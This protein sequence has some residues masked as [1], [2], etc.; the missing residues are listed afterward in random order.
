MDGFRV[1]INAI[2]H[3]QAPPSPYTP[4]LRND[5]SASQAYQLP[6]VPVIRIF[7]ATTAG[8]KVC[9]HVHGFFPY[10]YVPYEGSLE[11]KK[12]GA[13]IYRL[14]VSID[15]ALSLIVRRPTSR[16]SR[17]PKFVARITLV[18]GV[19]FYGFHVGYS[20]FLKIYMF[21]PNIMNRLVDVLQ[22]GAIM[23]TRFQPYEAHIQ[24]LSQFMIDYNLFGCDWLDADKTHFRAPLPEACEGDARQLPDDGNKNRLRGSESSLSLLYNDS[25]VPAC[26]VT[27]DSTLPRSSYCTLEVDIT[28]CDITN[29]R[30][31]TERCLHHDFIE[32]LYPVPESVKLVPSMAGLW[33]SEEQ[34]RRALGLL[35]SNSSPF[36]PDVL[37]SMSPDK[38]G[39]IE[40]GFMGEEEQRKQVA[41]LIKAEYDPNITPSFETFVKHHP[42]AD[43]VRTVMESVEDLYPDNLQAVLGL[44][45]QGVDDASVE[46]PSLED[47][48]VDEVQIS[49]SQ[50]PINDD[51]ANEIQDA[52][53]IDHMNGQA[54]RDFGAQSP[55]A[56][57]NE[58]ANIEG[59]LAS[60]VGLSRSGLYSGT[61]P[62]ISV[63]TNLIEA[64]CSDRF[65]P[66]LRRVP[67][68][69]K[70]RGKRFFTS[71]PAVTPDFNRKKM[72]IG[73]DPSFVPAA[74]KESGP[75]DVEETLAKGKANYDKK[76]VSFKPLMDANQALSVQRDSQPAMTED[77]HNIEGWLQRN[78]DL[79]SSSPESPSTPA[80]SRHNRAGF[81]HH[82]PL[83]VRSSQDA[84][85]PAGSQLF[86]ASSRAPPVSPFL[87]R[88]PRNAQ[89]SLI[90]TTPFK[91]PL[92]K[93]SWAV[94][95]SPFSIRKVGCSSSPFPACKQTPGSTTRS[96]LLQRTA[97]THTFVFS[98]PPPQ[99]AEVCSSFEQYDLPEVINEEVTY[100]VEADVPAR[101]HEY[102]GKTFRLRSNTLPFLPEFEIDA[103]HA[104][105]NS[106]LLDEPG[107]KI[108]KAR[109]IASQSRSLPQDV[110]CQMCSI[111]SWDFFPP[112]PSFQEVKA[113]DMARHVASM[114]SSRPNQ[115]LSSQSI[116]RSQRFAS[117]IDGPT[118]A[119]RGS[120]AITASQRQRSTGLKPETRSMS[121]LAIEVH[122]NT[123]GKLMPNPEH[124]SV[125]FV[126]WSLQTD[127]SYDDVV[128]L[129]DPTPDQ[130]GI[131]SGVI[132]LSE[133]S[134]E[135]AQ[136]IKKQT[137]WVVQAED[138][139]LE[140]LTAVA[141]MVRR[142]DP[143][144]LT[145][146]EVHS[147]SWGFLLER[148]ATKYEYDLG[149]DLSRMRGD[150]AS[151]L[152]KDGNGARWAFTK[153]STVKVTGRHTINIWRAMRGEMSLSQYTME[154]VAWHLLGRRIP[155]YSHAVLTAW[156]KAS[157]SADACAG[158]GHRA[159]ARLL[160]YYQLRTR[161]DLEIL[162]ANELVARTREQAR[163]LGVDFFSVIS[164]G[165]Q[166]K[167]ESMMGRIA[168]PENY[169]FVSPSRK[170]VGGQNA[171]ECLPLV[172]EP[173][174]ALYT[175]P[176]VVLD[177]QSL[178]PS[179]MIAYN[180]CYSTF[181][182]RIV[183]WGS[184]ATN[185]MGFTQYTRAKHLLTL[186][187]NSVTIAPNGMM[188]VT[189]AVRTSLLAKMLREIL[190]TRVMVK[191]GMKNAKKSVHQLLNNRQL[192]LKLLAN[193]TYG[194]TSASY[195]GR[196]PCAEIADSIVQT[197]R[198]TL[199][200]AIAL[201]H[202]HPSW[203]AEVVYGDTDSLFIRLPGRTK[204][205]AFSI[206]NEMA[207]AI[208]AAN[209]RP[210]KIK[211]EKIYQPCV[212]LAKKR[213]VG[214][215]WEHPSQDI[216]VFEAK[217]I[218]TVRRD[219]TPGEQK[220]QE[221]VLRTL[222]DTADLSRV[223]AYFQRQCDKILRGHV[224]LQ[225]FCF[226]K[227]VKLGTYADSSGGVHNYRRPNQP[228]PPALPPGALLAA[229][230]MLVDGRA[231]P[232]YGERVPYLV[233]AGAPGSRL[234]DRCVAPSEVLDSPDA[235]L[236]ADYYI[237]K[238]I[239]PAIDR[240][241]QLV[242]ASAKR[243]Y[244]E[245]PKVKRVRRIDPKRRSAILE[246]YLSVAACIA[247]K[248]HLP[249]R[250]AGTA[251][252]AKATPG[253]GAGDALI[254]MRCLAQRPQTLTTIQRRMS[255]LSTSLGN[256]RAVC[257][258]CAATA[259]GDDIDCDSLDCS[260]F[261]T[262][263]KM[264][265]RTR[266]EGEMLREAERKLLE[267]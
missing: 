223:K 68:T 56:A 192:A 263:S 253:G 153:T 197:S 266:S 109:A 18:K 97:R 171:L 204:A 159:M 29:R 260:V 216:P 21:N 22:N 19:P 176:V 256:I 36:P 43:T 115:C 151:R 15:H 198:E 265:A 220:I 154:N 183:G 104:S 47:I 131:V 246:A 262:R 167:V 12:V 66:G 239:I 33:R 125:Q 35:A 89:R 201:I 236:D 27:D 141:A 44:A 71:S 258:S 231:E 249:P 79:I 2:D 188:Y 61:P 241:L 240:I 180:Y 108:N 45:P 134:T 74:I 48:E 90:F 221:K 101:P 106:N 119:K 203:K 28:V 67:G 13:Y 3:Y 14:H 64:A 177:F 8:Q 233:I 46:N 149:E 135:L 226:A 132:V 215:K 161:L 172:M 120:V 157:S 72:K 191:S 210:V 117:Q 264:E 100:S 83:P 139:E 39:T 53:D 200:R 205:S 140:V 218:E 118:P 63:D 225:D 228:Q 142:F 25:T 227:E 82:S 160:R 237:N 124:D 152:H 23:Q 76:R 42:R 116:L 7:G 261:W 185:K 219:G 248:S 128:D 85:S 254:C 250:T 147:G 11:P 103:G 73:P 165:S 252:T 91:T 235:E 58:E 107:S 81:M 69:T 207:V 166:F 190:E 163:L 162:E 242:G 60:F 93:L 243:W 178:Y 70:A 9:A 187:Q 230:K 195:S 105:S 51:V 212:L 224:S 251:I 133:E 55:E 123:R 126:F 217:G 222:F 65:S 24:Y 181:L 30:S 75:L 206:A 129:E 170:Q 143:D 96:L 196:M 137:K 150:L 80:T 136:R 193:V 175:D 49:L 179:V 184:G 32:R 244:D 87:L 186:V 245:M 199:E 211:F 57:E 94:S 122:V 110:R 40:T 52:E 155:H 84:L 113:W 34:R 144:I 259:F 138:T 92:S 4:V 114:S 111:K 17:D 267:W 158:G 6:H 130:A 5:V 164:R 209:P 54:Q 99:V 238:N 98:T 156:H 148:A 20:F 234:S 145:G 102:G 10:V 173:Q 26:F 182:G 88:T 121:I 78:T 31:L 213:Y 255:A 62:K 127:Q 168:K 214:Y 257:R 86:I 229:R 38:K 41:Q 189:P 146:F 59:L 37:V 50:D 208:T 232:Q 77:G 112:P 1:Q 16:L 247:C 95:S 174:S 169:V 202:T 194:Y